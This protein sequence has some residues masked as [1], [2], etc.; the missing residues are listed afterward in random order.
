M[1]GPEVKKRLDPAL[2][3]MVKDYDKVGMWCN[4]GAAFQ[5]G[6]TAA[7]TQKPLKERMDPV[8]KSMVRDYDKVGMWCNMG[9][10]LTKAG[11]TKPVNYRECADKMV[12]NYDKV[13]I[14]CNMGGHFDAAQ[15]PNL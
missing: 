8:L 7:E 11:E 4:M 6:N 5:D 13:G 2:A 3:R 12:S 1:Q 10:S 14:W 15:A 9:G